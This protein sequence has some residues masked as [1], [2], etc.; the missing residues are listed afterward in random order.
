[1]KSRG[2]P[3]INTEEHHEKQEK[4][5]NRDEQ[6]STAFFAFAPIF[7]AKGVLEYCCLLAKYKHLK[8]YKKY[9]RFWTEQVD[10]R[11]R[12][13]KLGVQNKYLLKMVTIFFKDTF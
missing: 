10:G 9:V 7:I 12:V 5:E 13:P 1:M 3:S 8:W 11:G 4:L 2:K 6:I